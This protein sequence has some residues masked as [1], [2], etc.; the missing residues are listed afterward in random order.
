MASKTLAEINAIVRFR[1]DFRNTL[2]FPDANVNAEIQAAFGELYELIADTNEGHWDTAANVSTAAN[3]AFVALPADA[4][5]VRGIDRLDSPDFIELEQVGISDRNRYSSTTDKPRA[6]RLTARGVDLFPT[7]DAIYT[8]RVTYTPSAPTLSAARDYYSGWE[9]FV[10]YGALL[11]LALNEE[12]A[13]GDW[14]RQLEAQR[15]RIIRGASG[16]K[17][18]EPE[19]IPLREG[20][21][22]DNDEWWR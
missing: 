10:I 20:A 11:R 16:R 8:L 18:Q 19:Y 7:P 6:Y 13:T 3:T 17:A 5:R 1:G 2:R 14:E 4:W 22:Y 15:G 21:G 12:R 9:E